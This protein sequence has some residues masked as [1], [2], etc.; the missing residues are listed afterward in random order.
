MFKLSDKDKKQRKR[1]FMNLKC[2][3]KCTTEDEKDG[4]DFY[5]VSTSTSNEDG[6]EVTKTITEYTS[7][8]KGEKVTKKT[9][10]YD[11]KYNLIDSPSNLSRKIMKIEDPNFNPIENAG[12]SRGSKTSVKELPTNERTFTLKQ[13]VQDP[14]LLTLK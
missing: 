10:E 7:K 1:A 13:K 9:V 14:W 2:A 11:Y 5:N 6:R 3:P 12:T 4:N 8:K